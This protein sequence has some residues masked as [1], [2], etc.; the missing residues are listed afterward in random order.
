MKAARVRI[1]RFCQAARLT[2]GDT[3]SGTLIQHGMSDRLPQLRRER[4]R[5]PPG[6]IRRS[7]SRKID[8][9][10]VRAGTR[11]FRANDLDAVQR[12][13]DPVNVDLDGRQGQEPSL[14]RRGFDAQDVD[15]DWGRIRHTGREPGAQRL[16]TR[17]RSECG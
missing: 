8:A 15:A 12:G 7:I 4:Q 5:L 3:H 9:T 16:V 17:I 2:A 10:R 11:V 13:D 1:L 14:R 6:T